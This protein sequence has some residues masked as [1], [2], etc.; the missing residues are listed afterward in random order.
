[1]LNT[2]KKGKPEAAVWAALAAPVIGVPLMV[3]LLALTAPTANAVV[4]ESEVG[5]TIE[6]VQVQA[7]DYVAEDPC[8]YIEQPK[9]F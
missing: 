5:V 9:R 4:R 7:V 1:M 2:N 8:E 3:A 6:Q